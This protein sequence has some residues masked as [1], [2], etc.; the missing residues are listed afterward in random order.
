M[1]CPML[2][3]LFLHGC[4]PYAQGL[5]SSLT[6]W[7]I[8]LIALKRKLANP[9]ILFETMNKF[10]HVIYY[11]LYMLIMQAHPYFGRT[12]RL[13]SHIT[14]S[15]IHHNSNHMSRLHSYIPTLVIHPDSDRTSRLRSL[16]EPCVLPPRLMDGFT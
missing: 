10:F 4:A 14:F 1:P 6:E 16:V 2:C 12:S 8:Q 15:V 3:G 13:R 11:P 7:I 5:R 9:F